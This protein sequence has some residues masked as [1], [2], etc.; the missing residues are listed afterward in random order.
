MMP[1]N[2]Y[3]TIDTGSTTFVTSLSAQINQRQT[4]FYSG[5]ASTM[6]NLFEA[7]DTMVTVGTS[8]FFRVINCAYS[9]QAR[10]YNEPFDW[11]TFDFS[12][13]HT[14][15][16]SW[17][18]TFDASS[19]ELPEYNDQHNLYPTRQSNVNAARCNYPL[20]EV[21]TVES[22]FLEGKLG[23]DTNG[24]RVYEPRDVH[25]GR[26]A[27]ALMYMAT[28]YNG[29]N[30]NNWGFTQNIGVC[31]GT[32]I[33]Y[34]QD[35]NVLKRWHLEHLPDAYDIAR[36]DFLDSLQQNRNPFVDRPEYAC[37]INFINMS[38]IANPPA[39]CYEITSGINE[40]PAAQWNLWPNPAHDLLNI[41][42]E[43]AAMGN[44][45]LIVTDLAGKQLAA[46]PLSSQT[47]TISIAELSKGLYF[48]HLY[49]NGVHT[50]KTFGKQ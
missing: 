19:P 13:E 2:E 24:R 3:A 15:A 17:M 41:R 40:S 20:G 45:T 29:I 18:P 5:Y 38:Y 32:S 34:G 21:V 27:R 12:R 49:A 1:A 4:V 16:H 7:R 9:G 8:K 35:Q 14:Y 10:P 22:N 39:T 33:P 48:L 23:L 42:L 50:V 30:N 6:I 28:C 37:R 26:A 43:Q 46:H 31:Q 47:E 25:K 44:A 36:N 11:T